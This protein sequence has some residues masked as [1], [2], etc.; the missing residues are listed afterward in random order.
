MKLAFLGSTCLFVLLSS[1]NIG[2]RFHFPNIHRP[3]DDLG[4]KPGTLILLF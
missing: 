3:R 1:A 2:T 4:K